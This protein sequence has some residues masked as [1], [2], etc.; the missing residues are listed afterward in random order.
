MSCLCDHQAD[1]SLHDHLAENEIDYYGEEPSMSPRAPPQQYQPPQPVMHVPNSSFSAQTMSRQGL[2]PEHCDNQSKDSVF[3]N[4]SSSP[5]R[6]NLQHYQIGQ[7][8]CFSNGVTIGSN[9]RNTDQSFFHQQSRECTSFCFND[10]AMDM[11]A[12]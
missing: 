1:D 7:E 4:E 12:D 11:H 2:R 6:Q 5:V 9:N 10:T 8:G 3:S